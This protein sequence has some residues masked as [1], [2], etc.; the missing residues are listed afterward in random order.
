MKLFKKMV[1]ILLAVGC[2][3]LG[4][5]SWFL[6]RTNTEAL[7]TSIFEL[8][9]EQASSLARGVSQQLQHVTETLEGQAQQ[10]GL[11][12]YDAARLDEAARSLLSKHR[13]DLNVVS[14]WRD[15]SAEPLA[16][17]FF[18]AS[19][20]GQV[21]APSEV[22]AAHLQAVART[23][24]DPARAVFSEVYWT[25]SE[26]PCVTAILPVPG[27]ST[28]L[29]AEIR[30][31]GIQEEVMRTRVGPGGRVWVVDGK[32]KVIAARDVAQARARADRH[33]NE[34]VARAQS[35]LLSG[36]GT[37]TDERG[38]E[39]LAA[40]A[41]ARHVG[42][43]VI[44]EEPRRVA[45]APA[46][47]MFRQTVAIASL[48]MV[49][50]ILAG[51]LFA[52]GV[53]NPI[54]NVVVA[55][56]SIARGKFGHSL[57]VDRGDEIGE[58]A[59]TFNY[60]SRQLADYDHENKRL[61]QDLQQ[62]YLETIRALANSI[63]AKD[64]YTRGHSQRVTEYSVDIA[65]ALG[66]GE[67]EIARIQFG[68][69]LHDIGKI[70]IKEK[71]LGKAAPLTDEEYE[72]MKTHPLLGVGIVDPIEF[73]EQIKPI[74]RN[75]HERWDGKGYPDG[76]A[77]EAI[78]LGARIVSIADAWDAMVTQRPY[79][80]P[81]T[82][83]QGVARLKQIGGTQHDPK[84]TEI[85]LAVLVRRRAEEQAGDAWRTEQGSNVVELPKRS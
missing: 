2:L 60:M 15:R 85:F 58:L 25:A 16:I 41:P 36:S 74:I 50:A 7:R 56:L 4:V 29:A 45:L 61:F 28:L 48:T 77:G 8:H 70:G 6:I 69:I 51:L 82:W 44:V 53:V 79:N 11:D 9:L 71:I 34:I 33:E 43:T 72:Y 3:P 35:G 40:F 1:L 27:S 23:R 32:G 59:H 19:V 10:P 64:P 65:Q 83:E 68:G 21:G 39:M 20:D 52:R 38:E 22:T 14:M 75:H 66:L 84:I 13:E 37:Y 62:G 12:E 49:V 54:R 18:R 31:A 46:T 67:E 47:R 30:I 63:D 26:D 17:A 80:T 76:L 81:M 57:E 73:L 55:S 78:D 42:W 24:P 5:A